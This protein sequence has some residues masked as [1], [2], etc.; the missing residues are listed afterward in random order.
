[1]G[2]SYWFEC[3][4]C[5]YRAAVSGRADQGLHCFVQTILCRDCRQL[6][7]A[8]T[9]IRIAGPSRSG[10]KA[11]NRAGRTSMALRPGLSAERPPSFQSALNRLRYLGGKLQWVDV[12]L[13]CPVSRLHRIETWEGPGKC[14]KCGL[15]LERNVLPYRLWD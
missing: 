9:R 7:D 11:D 1:M 6:Y 13:Q 2:R 5:G 8:V 10:P 12:K 15:H 4:K 3:V 14:P